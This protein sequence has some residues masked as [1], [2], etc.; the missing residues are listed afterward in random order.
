MKGLANLGNT[1]YLNSVLQ[2]LFNT[3][4]FG[5]PVGIVDHQS[6]DPMHKM[7]SRL[8]RLMSD[9]HDPTC[10]SLDDSLRAFFSQFQICHSQFGYGQHDQH[11]YL[12]FLL[13]T[14]HDT[15]NVP[16]RLTICGDRTPTS[17]ADRLELDSIKSL[18]MEG[19]SLSTGNLDTRDT[20]CYNSVVVEMFTGQYRSQTQCQNTDCKYISD[21]FECFRCCELPIGNQD[22]TS[23][24]ISDVLTEFVSV[25]QLDDGYE[26]DRCGQRTRSK[27]RCTFW[28]LPEVLIFNLKRIMHNGHHPSRDDRQVDATQVLDM[29][30]YLT[31]PRPES[32][33]YELYATG[34]HHGTDG[35]GHCYAQIRTPDGWCTANDDR[36]ISGLLPDVRHS[37]LLFY[38]RSR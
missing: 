18:R 8:Y 28:R 9:Y 15:V 22:R 38:R 13:R 20:L 27:R 26:C 12:T 29:S 30:A 32:S 5:K 24:T 31:A 14:V 10:S 17:Y 33:K 25:T 37:Y 23:V 34:N 19:M 1:C 3:G 4:A 2:I 11:E 35:G 7:V 36:L 6:S 16:S 21:R